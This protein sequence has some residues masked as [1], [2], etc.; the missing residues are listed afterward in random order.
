MAT[1]LIAA[2]C[3][4]EYEAFADERDRLDCEITAVCNAEQPACDDVTA[5]PKGDCIRFRPAL[6]DQCL[7]DMEQ[8]LL[9]VEQ[10][11]EGQCFEFDSQACDD[12]TEWANRRPGCQSEEGRPIRDEGVALLAAIRHG[13]AW[14]PDTPTQVRP[15]LSPEAAGRRWLAIARSEH[16]SIAAFSDIALQLMQLG[17]PPHLIEGCHRAALDEVRHARDALGIACA[18]TGDRLDLGAL[19]QPPRSTPTLRSVALDALIEGCIGEG[20]AAARAARGADDAEPDVAAVLRGVAADETRHAAL[21]WS[22][23]RWALQR[24]PS[25]A[26]DLHRALQEAPTEPPAPREHPGN[27]R[28]GLLDGATEAQ[29]QRDIIEQV[30]TPVLSS[31]T[32]AVTSTA[33]VAVARSA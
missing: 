11:A 27:L 22:T 7:A 17:A 13:D 12:V 9:R 14:L 16:A 31:L 1:F 19:P 3:A 6:A 33:D 26:S 24:D 32:A 8:W 25:L 5:A 28:L 21:A 15:G 23:L 2:G 30:V 18:L 20:V 10:D 29:L 4:A